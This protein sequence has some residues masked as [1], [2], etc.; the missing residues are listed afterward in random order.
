MPPPHTWLRACCV[1]VPKTRSP[2][3]KH[4]QGLQVGWGRGGRRGDCP[5]TPTPPSPPQ[6]LWLLQ[7]LRD[8]LA[9]GLMVVSPGTNRGSRGTPPPSRGALCGSFGGW[10]R[11]RELSLSYCLGLSKSELGA[12][13]AGFSL[14]CTRRGWNSELFA[15]DVWS[16]M[17]SHRHF[18]RVSSLAL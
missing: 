9:R 10:G 13:G 3:F 14:A 16:F 12:P 11:G 17:T 2:A 18:L 4:L 5:P 6:V 8:C 1:S 15:A 7:P